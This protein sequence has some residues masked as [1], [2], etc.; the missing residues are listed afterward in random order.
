[1]PALATD[2]RFR[3]NAERVANR[4]VLRPIVAGVLAG[5]STAEWVAA[6]TAAEVPVGEVRDMAQVFADPGLTERAMV[7]AVHHP[8]VGEL[9]L[10]GIPAR[11]SRTPGSIRRP[12]PLFAEHQAEILGELEADATPS[13]IG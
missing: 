9:R 12:P 13:T 7:V 8:T 10:P 3:T 1:M 2:P 11:L 6:L 5:R 4:A